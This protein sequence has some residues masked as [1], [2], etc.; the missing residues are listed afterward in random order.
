MNL[1]VSHHAFL[2]ADLMQEPKRPRAFL[3]E[4]AD[5]AVFGPKATLADPPAP[6]LKVWL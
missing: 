2:H 6:D 3:K 1:P 5:C 4:I